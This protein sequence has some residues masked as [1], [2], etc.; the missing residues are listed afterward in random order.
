VF[1][2]CQACFSLAAGEAFFTTKATLYSMKNGNSVGVLSF[3]VEVK[4]VDKNPKELYLT[5]GDKSNE[6]IEASG[7]NKSLWIFNKNRN[8]SDLK[9]DL[10]NRDYP[11]DVKD[12]RDFIPFSENEIR[13]DL[14]DWEEIKKQTKFTFYTNASAGDKITLRM[15]F[16]IASKSKNKTVIDDEAKI[17]LEF[18][19][20]QPTTGN[21]KKQDDELVS[22]T[23]KAANQ[24]AKTP[25]EQQDDSL[26]QAEEKERIQQTNDLNVF[27]T[28]KNKEITSLQED[29]NQLVSAKNSKITKGTLDS[30]QTIV[31]SLRIKVKYRDQ[32]YTAIILNN[33]DLQNKFIKFNSDQSV[34]SKKLDELRQQQSEKKSRTLTYFGIGLG[35]LMIGGMFFMQIWNMTKMKR[36]IWKQQ[37]MLKEEARKRAFESIDINDLD[38]I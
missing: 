3:G 16:Y 6:I 28:Q 2:C 1:F 9:K 27:I 15:H 34:I 11:L 23:D 37:N 36:Q 26:K 5:I 20:P 13:F 12:I 14:K 29:I 7:N 18:T 24:P 8:A 33:E 22:L 4:S 38:K 35:A 10:K 17:K 30:L 25:Q 32:G 31:D 21:G 19:L